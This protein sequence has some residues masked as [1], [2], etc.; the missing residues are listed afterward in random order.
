MQSI[1]LAK[2]EIYQEMMKID[3]K[4]NEKLLKL[5]VHIKIEQLNNNSRR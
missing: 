2:S 4:K 5:Q 3:L 1:Y